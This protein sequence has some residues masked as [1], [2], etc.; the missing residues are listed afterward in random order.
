MS[1]EAEDSGNGAQA[2]SGAKFMGGVPPIASYGLALQ[3]EQSWHKMAAILYAHGTSGAQIARELDKTPQAVSNLIRQPFFQE[4][5]AGIM[6]ET[7]RDIIGTFQGREGKLSG[8]AGCDSRRSR[9]SGQCEGNGL[10]GYSGSKPRKSRA[11][12]RGCGRSDE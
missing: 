12:D 7:A 11:K 2:V 8:D 4:R 5:V 1:D 10:Q 3:K 6:A 9:D